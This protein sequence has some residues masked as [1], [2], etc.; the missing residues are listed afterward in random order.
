MTRPCI[1]FC[2]SSVVFYSRRV[3]EPL[4]RYTKERRGGARCEF[5]LDLLWSAAALFEFVAAV[6]LVVLPRLVSVLDAVQLLDALD[7]EEL[8][9]VELRHL[10]EPRPLLALLFRRLL[11][12][13]LEELLHTCISTPQWESMLNLRK[14]IIV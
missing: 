1:E 9:V 4:D 14:R 11:D 7:V 2:R 8:E 6:H 10:G 12:A 5:L 3:C 13:G